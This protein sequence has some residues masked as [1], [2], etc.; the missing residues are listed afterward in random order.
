MFNNVKIKL[1][2]LT[3]TKKDLEWSIKQIKMI[4]SIENHYDE[5]LS[6]IWVC[7]FNKIIDGHHRYA[8]LLNKFGGEHE[9]VVKKF[10][11]SQ[12][13]YLTIVTSLIVLSLLILSP[14]YIINEHF[15]FKKW[16]RKKENID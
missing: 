14:L 6:L 5:R 9:I 3:P 16:L 15:N 7:K 2:D 8:I 11:V 4:D 12:K 13:T 1:K 10:N